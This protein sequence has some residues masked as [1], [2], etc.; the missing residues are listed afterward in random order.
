MNGRP[1]WQ[2]RDPIE[3]N[4]AE[5][6]ERSRCD[7]TRLLLEK[8]PLAEDI[9]RLGELDNRIRR[10]VDELDPPVLHDEQLGA[11]IAF[12]E[13]HLAGRAGAGKRS[14]I[15]V[16]ALSAHRFDFIVLQYRLVSANTAVTCGRSPPPLTGTSALACATKPPRTSNC[17]PIAVEI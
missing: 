1:P 9:T 10:A 16:V 14:E 6:R 4:D 13:N 7:V 2:G 15:V 11:G 12:V 8:R 17:T 3:A 5:V